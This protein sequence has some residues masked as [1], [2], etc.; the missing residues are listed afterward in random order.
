MPAAPLVLFPHLLKPFL[1]GRERRSLSDDLS[2][3]RFLSHNEHCRPADRRIKDHGIENSAGT[4]K[5]GRKRIKNRSWPRCDRFIHRDPSDPGSGRIFAGTV[6]GDGRCLDL[7]L[8]TPTRFF[9]CRSQ[10]YLRVQ[11]GT[12]RYKTAG[13]QPAD[14]TGRPHPGCYPALYRPPGRC[15]AGHHPSGRCR[16]HCRGS[17]CRRIFHP[18]ALQANI[19]S[20]KP[21]GRCAPAPLPGH[22]LLR[23]GT[24]CLL[25]SSDREPRGACASPEHRSGVHSR[26]PRALR[27][28]RLRSRQRVRCTDRHGASMHPLSVGAYRIHRHRPASGSQAA[29]TS[30]A[31]SSVHALLRKAVLS[32]FT[33]GA[34][35]CLFFLVFGTPAGHFLFH[36]EDA[37]RFIITLAWI[38]PFFI[39]TRSPECAERIREDRFRVSH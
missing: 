12:W 11:S 10:L 26:L 2:G 17:G 32:C 23:P 39:L 14:R 27:D 6:L 29:S 36:S 24:A 1:R 25:G 7:I 20:G 19:F 21:A 38:C 22:P 13:A 33:L 35:S 18:E 28:V 8:I 9:C 4:K 5:R 37:G 34:V 31:Q 3:I 15:N 16:H 30:G